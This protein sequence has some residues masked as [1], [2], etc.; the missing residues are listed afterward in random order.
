MVVIGPLGPR[1]L[2]GGQFEKCPFGPTSGSVGWA[3]RG[4]LKSVGTL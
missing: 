2:R 3:R 1:M 4:N